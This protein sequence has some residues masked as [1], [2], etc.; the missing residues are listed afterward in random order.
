MLE[1]RRVLEDLLHA[2]HAGHAV[3]D[4]NQPF[5]REPLARGSSVPGLGHARGRIGISASRAT[6]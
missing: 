1:H 2:G 3:A 5:H 4:D 6:T